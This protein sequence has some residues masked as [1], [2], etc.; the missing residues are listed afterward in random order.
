M[1]RAALIMAIAILGT[2]APGMTTVVGT[3]HDLSAAL[4]NTQRVCV[5]CHTPHQ[6]NGQSTDP[7]W[8]H[9]LSTNPTYGVYASSTLNASP[10]ELGSG[11]TV[12]NLCLSCHDGT[13]GIGSLYNDPNSTGGA[14]ETP[15]NSATMITGN[16]NVG[17]DLTNDHPINFTYDLALANEDGELVDPSGAGAPGDWLFNGTVQ[18]ASCHDPHDDTNIPFLIATNV[19]SAMCTTCHVK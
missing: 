17:T 19:A 3:Q 12:S 15:S 14:E 7:L 8:N 11:T 16:A 18:C 4:P 1:R 9:T 6:P 13:I 5:F 2:A 10:T